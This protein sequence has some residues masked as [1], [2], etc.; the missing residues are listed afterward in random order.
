MPLIDACLERGQS[1]RRKQHQEPDQRG[2]G[3]AGDE[4][5]L[6]RFE[7]EA[8]QEPAHEIDAGSIGTAREVEPHDEEVHGKRAADEE[9]DAEPR[10]AP[11]GSRRRIDIARDLERP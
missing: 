5:P 11:A 2:E 7:R 4:N 3:A 10:P 1:G 6:G 8:R 9:K